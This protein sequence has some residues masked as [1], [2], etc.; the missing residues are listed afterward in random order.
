[1]VLHIDRRKRFVA[2]GVRPERSARFNRHVRGIYSTVVASST[3]SD[4]ESE[5]DAEWR[6]ALRVQLLRSGPGAFVGLRSAARL[7]GLEGFKDD[8]TVET[9]TPHPH[10][11]R[12]DGV[13]R[14]E[15]LQP[16]QV[17]T[18]DEF[19]VTSVARTLLDLG[20]VVTADQLEFAVE[21]ALRGPDP[22]KPYQWNRELLVELEALTEKVRAR[23]GSAVLARV[24]R[25]RPVGCRPTGSYAETSYVQALRQAGLIGVRRQIDVR[26]IDP[27]GE[28][29][30]WYFPDLGF[31]ERLFLIEINGAHYRG[32]ATMTAADVKRHN[33]LSEVFRVHVV[34]GADAVLSRNRR[35][36][37][38]RVRALIL[39]E[40]EVEFPVTVRGA[41]IHQTPTGFDVYLAR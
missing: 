1:M 29:L 31:G 41:R 7:H 30:H 39:A 11:S 10:H 5:D 15:T 27:T 3:E 34:S 28:V 18:V 16:D 35:S 23:T 14:T 19:P 12:A 2:E 26:L 32:G 33:L 21:H 13:H 22:G 40:P 25:R 9:I 4:D 20:R 8:A 38:A 37:A 36:S 6:A 17:V 24:L